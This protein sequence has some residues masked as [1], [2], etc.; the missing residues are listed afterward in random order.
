MDAP[1][2]FTPILQTRVWGGEILKRRAAEPPA[3]P[4]GESWEIADCGAA[5]VSYTHL[6]LPTIYS[7]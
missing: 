4:V 5:A 7:V 2:A 3:D 6:T 1:L